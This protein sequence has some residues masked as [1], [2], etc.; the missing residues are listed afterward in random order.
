[1]GEG[2]VDLDLVL[3]HDDGDRSRPEGAGL[4]VKKGIKRKMA[5][6]VRVRVACPLVDDP[7][8]GCKGG[9]DWPGRLRQAPVLR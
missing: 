7:D 8:P 1:M 5:H 3:G 2:A 4:A 9:G 6:G